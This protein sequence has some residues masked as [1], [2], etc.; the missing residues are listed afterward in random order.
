MQ[1]R[2]GF[3]SKSYKDSLGKMTGGTGHL[4]TAAEIATYPEGTEIPTAV[5][6]AWFDVDIAEAMAD[7]DEQGKQIPGNN[8]EFE[9]ALVSMNF[10]LC[11]DW[12][13][14]FPTAWKHMK[15]GNFKGAAAELE[16]TSEGSGVKSDWWKQTKIRVKDM[17]KALSKME[18][19]DD[20]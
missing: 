9:E 17:K 11:G 10:Q 1:L 2:E 7:A 13:D 15:S 8:P 12:M 19:Q 20:L 3:D 18:V 4:M 16:Y 5:T 6:D 14:K